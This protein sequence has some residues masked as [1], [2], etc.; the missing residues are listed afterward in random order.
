MDK[1]QNMCNHSAQVFEFVY[2]TPPPP[3]FCFKVERIRGAQGPGYA[4][5]NTVHSEVQVV[6]AKELRMVTTL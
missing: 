3:L 1:L 4:L 2:Q 5:T 6:V